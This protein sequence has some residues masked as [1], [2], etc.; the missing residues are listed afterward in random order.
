MIGSYGYPIRF[1]AIIIYNF[2][3]M[4]RVIKYYMHNEKYRMRYGQSVT[5]LIHSMKFFALNPDNSTLH[6]QS[7][8]NE[9]TQINN[10]PKWN[11]QKNNKSNTT[12][13]SSINK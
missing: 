6:T 10:H 3:H 8:V 11:N 1:A 13:F 12:R 7:I 5:C 2:L 9:R 4:H